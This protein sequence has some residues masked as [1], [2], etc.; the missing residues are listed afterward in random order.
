MLVWVSSLLDLLQTGRFGVGE[1]LV[2][3][4]CVWFFAPCYLIRDCVVDAI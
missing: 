3:G 4:L 1:W 2:G